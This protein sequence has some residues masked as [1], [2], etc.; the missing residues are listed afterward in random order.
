MTDIIRAA[1]RAQQGGA[2]QKPIKLAKTVSLNQLAAAR[3]RKLNAALRCL[4]HCAAAK[5]SKHY[6]QDIGFAVHNVRLY[7]PRGWD[8][9]SVE[10][11]TGIVHINT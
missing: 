5:S 10:V 1:R 9:T 6:Y 3:N 8:V 11:D 2:G 4:K 7:L